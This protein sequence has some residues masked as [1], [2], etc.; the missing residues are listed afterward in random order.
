MITLIMIPR[1]T[2]LRILS[3]SQRIIVLLPSPEIRLW[4]ESF[5]LL[6]PR[7]LSSPV[8]I[9]V[10]PLPSWIRT[11]IPGVHGLGKVLK[12]S[13]R[14]QWWRYEWSSWA[15]RDR[16]WPWLHPWM[17]P[18]R[19]LTAGDMLW[20]SVWRAIVAICVHRELHRRFL[21]R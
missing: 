6:G 19:G 15:T 5:V 13:W 14:R 3:L 20:S 10:V 9:F 21:P 17:G 2:G 7:V 4:V 8:D 12:G 18:N 1:E 11:Q 16:Y